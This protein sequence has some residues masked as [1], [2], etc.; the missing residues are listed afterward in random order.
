CGARVAAGPAA[1][2][3]RFPGRE[4]QDRRAPREYPRHRQ[5]QR[6]RHQEHRDAAQSGDR[7]LAAEL[8]AHAR[9]GI[10]FRAARAARAGRHDAVRSLALPMDG[11]ARRSAA[12]S[13]TPAT[14]QSPALPEETPLPMPV[15]S[16]RAKPPAAGVPTSPPGIARRRAQLLLATLALTAFGGY[17]MYLVF[18]VGGLT[19]L[20][21]AI[22]VIYV[23]L[24]A[25]IAFSFV[26]ASAGFL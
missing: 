19:N 18:Q 15:Q 8:R 1:L 10:A 3:A 14:P 26:T 23:F 21:A 12:S 4:S 17:E 6:G 24:F 11:V 20:E 13:G 2:R 5:R 9:T 25:W 16:L 22:L 7:R